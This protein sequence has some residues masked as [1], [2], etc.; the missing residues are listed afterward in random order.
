MAPLGTQAR[1]VRIVVVLAVCLAVALSAFQ[2]FHQRLS[3][4]VASTSS[5]KIF[6]GS[7]TDNDAGPD[8]YCTAHP[9]ECGYAAMLCDDELV[10]GQS[11]FRLWLS[12]GGV[13]PAPACQEVYTR[14]FLG[15]T[16]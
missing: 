7:S 8:P 11:L 10:R 5:L 1:R 15:P 9:E 3:S 16:R 2:P 12:P 13:R 4:A 6:S 14:R